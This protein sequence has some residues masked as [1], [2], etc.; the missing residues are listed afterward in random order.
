M[1]ISIKTRRVLCPHNTL[2]SGSTM[3][4]NPMLFGVVGGQHPTF[5]K[6]NQNHLPFTIHY[7]LT[8]TGGVP[9]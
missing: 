7:S 2:A 5:R 4:T 3:T 9:C 6:A 1:Q 8:P